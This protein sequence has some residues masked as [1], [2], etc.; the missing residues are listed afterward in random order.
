[1]HREA[2]A[3]RDVD[4]ALATEWLV[5]DGAG[6]YASSTV[7]GCGTRRY[8]GLWVPAL[9]P[10]VDRRVVLAHVQER[11]VTDTGGA[12]LSTCEYA[13]GFH[14][15]GF[16]VAERFELDPFP[17]LA[18]RVG[19]FTVER[20]VLLLRDGA[21]V[22]LNYR[23]R[24]PGRWMLEV[25]PFLAARP[26]HHFM[27]RH[28]NFRVEA[29]PDACGFRFLAEGM[30]GV[31][32]WT[33]ARA[34]VSVN[35]TWYYGVLRRTERE[36]GFDHAEDLLAPGR[37]NVNGT[38]RAEWSLFC[39]FDPPRSM[40]VGA[41]KKRALASGRD[42]LARAGRPKDERLARL[43]LAADAFL[44]RRPV[45]GK[46]LATIIAGY[47]WFG[48]WG[49]DTM[50]ALPGLAMET[51]RLDMAERVFEAFASSESDGLIPN[52]FAEETGRPEYNTVDASLWFLQAVAA[53]VRAGG[54]ADFVR[55]TLWR[56][57]CDI[58]ERYRTGTR[59]DIRADA[60]GLITA[61]SA[62]TQ[63]TWMDAASAGSPVT[64]RYGKAVEI[65]ALWISGLALME[66]IADKLDLEVPSAVA[67]GQRARQAFERVFW[68]EADGCLYDCVRPDG[69]PRAMMR[70][71]QILA[72]GLPHAPLAGR[73]GRAVVRRVRE[74]LLT[75]RGLRTLAPSDPAYC[76]TYTGGPDARGAAYHRGTAWPWLLGPYADAIFAV[77][78]AACA[79]AEAA[80]LLDGLLDSLDEAGLGQI[81]EIFD[82]DPP[83][84]PRGCIAQAWSV[85]AAIHVW[86]RLE[87]AGGRL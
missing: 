56:A 12:Y 16:Q 50:I 37:W 5:A 6:G 33:D 49:R 17:L 76:G 31:F 10:P 83:H 54:R 64:P 36:R 26:I 14:P 3:L 15:D 42:L 84:R 69:A 81:S 74:T 85:A 53:Y 66:D 13:D 43:V 1:M 60:D 39:S 45:G 80:Q 28:E 82:G 75:P 18:S 51:G 78:D 38:G 29:L 87:A 65:N 47:H 48:D 34:D 70:P 21:G 25:A 20:E 61:G 71:N 35:P 46:D 4:C 44:V 7:L 79:R 24:G 68:N 72:V 52:R 57:A 86:R 23:V 19:E 2:T 77:E 55:H 9:K 8:H 32:L 73:R 59:F 40:D 27:H 30:P 63:L 62:G 22:C 67:D 58:C 41:E 11:L